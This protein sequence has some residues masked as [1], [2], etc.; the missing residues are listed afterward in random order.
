MLCKHCGNMMTSE[1]ITK[2]RVG[3]DEFA[4]CY[5][6]GAICDLSIE[7]HGRGRSKQIKILSERWVLPSDKENDSTV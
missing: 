7:E 1:Y 4:T 6:C 5:K 2:P 3:Y